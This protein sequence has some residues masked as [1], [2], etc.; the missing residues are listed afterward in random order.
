MA[1]ANSKYSF[2]IDGS[3][4]L[5]VHPKSGLHTF[6]VSGTCTNSE[7][8]TFAFI[9]QNNLDLRYA[10][11]F[12]VN[13]NGTKAR[14][15]EVVGFGIGDDSLAVAHDVSDNL[16]FTRGARIAIARKCIALHPSETQVGEKAVE[17]TEVTEETEES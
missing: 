2:I 9:A 15:P 7:G 8:D 14:M 12:K 1:T 4:K 11:R 17:V 6:V 5:G 13:W 3:E 10:D 16:F